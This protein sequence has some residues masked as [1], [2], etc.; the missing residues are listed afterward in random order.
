[1]I[2]L[3]SLNFELVCRAAKDSRYNHYYYIILLEMIL[4]PRTSLQIS[5]FLCLAASILRDES[6]PGVFSIY[7]VNIYLIP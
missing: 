1:M 4:Y 3:N 5:C 2:C 7:H 6:K